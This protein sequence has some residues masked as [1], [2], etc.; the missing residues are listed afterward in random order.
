MET[1]VRD[2]VKRQIIES[3]MLIMRDLR[4]DKPLAIAFSEQGLR[5]SANKSGVYMYCRGRVT[6]YKDALIAK[7][8]N[9]V[10]V[11][12]FIPRRFRNPRQFKEEM[13]WVS[14][15]L[16]LLHINN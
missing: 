1:K 8:S 12:P 2:D 5:L 13:M 6:N 9:R 11:E 15:G 14:K 7:R 16:H 3:G 10:K 4:T